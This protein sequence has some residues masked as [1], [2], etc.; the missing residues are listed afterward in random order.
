MELGAID[1]VAV[2]RNDA[3]QD[4]LLNAGDVQQLNE[5]LVNV[6]RR[7]GPRHEWC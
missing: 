5:N 2:M 4:V 3:S 1:A 6:S 7:D